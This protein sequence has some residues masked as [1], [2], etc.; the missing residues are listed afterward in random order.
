M[1]PSAAASSESL[2]F[3]LK[4]VVVAGS[5]SSRRFSEHTYS[6]EGNSS[7]YSLSHRPRTAD[8]DRSFTSLHSPD[9]P[10]FKR[11]HRRSD[12]ITHPSDISLPLPSPTTRSL[13]RKRTR[14]PSGRP[15]A[16]QLEIPP[17][18][19]P[20]PPLP[21]E[22]E[23][24]SRGSFLGKKVPPIRIPELGLG[25]DE[26][27][28]SPLS[29]PFPS[30]H[31]HWRD[32]PKQSREAAEPVSFLQMSSKRR[33]TRQSTPKRSLGETEA[34]AGCISVR[35]T[36]SLPDIKPTKRRSNPSFASRLFRLGT[37][38]F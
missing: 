29:P 3:S 28:R 35:T 12:S 4:D 15:V 9:S 8:V 25:L 32:G 33:S 36:H 11:K 38:Q 30:T 1:K 10:S 5:P 34:L 24:K 17:P 6:R 20:L 13:V 31:F 23:G 22:R 21:K 27:L 26:K 14:S 7:D 19:P 2:V 37:Q 18:V 16:T